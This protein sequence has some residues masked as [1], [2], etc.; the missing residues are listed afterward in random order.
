MNAVKLVFQIQNKKLISQS[1]AKWDWYEPIL[2]AIGV[3]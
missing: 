2:I 3:I 1:A